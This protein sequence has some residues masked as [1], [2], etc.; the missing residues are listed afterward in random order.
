MV[1]RGSHSAPENPPPPL[2][3]QREGQRRCSARES[4]AGEGE[5][6]LHT[7]IKSLIWTK[8]CASKKFLFFSKNNF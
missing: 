1:K 2:L 8:N 3:C 6:S 5:Y 7:G 4:C